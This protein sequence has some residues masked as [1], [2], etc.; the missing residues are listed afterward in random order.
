[1]HTGID[2]GINF[3][4]IGVDVVFRAIGLRVFLCPAVER[5]AFPCD[6]VIDE[7]LVVPRWIVGAR[8]LLGLQHEAEFLA[9]IGCETLFVVHLVEVEH[10]RELLERIHL[11]RGEHISLFHLL[12]HGVSASAGA[13]VVSHRIEIRRVLHHTDKGSRLLDAQVFRFFAEIDI[14]GTLDAHSVVEEVELVEIHLD[15]LILGVVAFE[16]YCNHPFDRLL[17]EA[18]QH[19]FRRR[20]V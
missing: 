6:R 3:Q 16:F 9:E 5:I 8:R 7:S 4:T 17:H 2:S 15:N 1:M 20:G 18:L 19:V 12:K 10:Q 14:G 13:F 11:L